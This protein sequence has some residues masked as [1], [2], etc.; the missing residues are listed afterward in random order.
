[1]LSLWKLR[2]GTEAYYLAQVATGLDD[3]YT[4]A[5]EAPG[6]WVGGGSQGLSLYGE[7]VAE[8][9][10]ATMAGLAPRTGLTPNGTQLRPH[11]RR[12]PGFDLTFAAPKSVSVLYALGD[13]RVQIAVVDACEAAVAEALAWLERE[14]CFVRRGTNNAAAKVATV[15]EWGTRRMATRGMVAAQFRHRTSRAG[16]PHLHWH[17]LVANLAQGVDGSWSALDGQALYRAKRTAGVL[18]QTALRAQLTRRLRLAWGPTHQDAAEVAGVPGRV[19]RA[20]STRRA[21]IEEWMDERGRHG[22]AAA[23]EAMA[24]T[25]PAK[26]GVDGAALEA[27][28]RGRAAALGWGPGELEQLLAGAP[29][30]VPA[31]GER[32]VLTRNVRDDDGQVVAQD[33]EVSFG[34]WVE[35]LVIERLSAHDSTFTR[36]D[37]TQA[38]AAATGPG[39][40][41]AEVDQVVRRVLAQPQLVPLAG[42]AEQTTALADRRVR[43]DRGV[44]WASREL[45][46]VEAGYL[47]WLRSGLGGNR[48]VLSAAA[49]AEAVVAAEAASPGS[50]GDLDDGLAAR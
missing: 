45:L 21:Q 35:E 24:A 31:A 30:P 40:S 5:G 8:D 26:P 6:R 19:L 18:F 36:F 43:D 16:D 44:R 41:P 22:P 32:W 48:A 10:R 1:M 23:D 29:A 4:G 28:W 15:G 7:V 12:V 2:V 37:L 34:A 11:P 39:A 17:V 13:A 27:D 49:A 46:E 3:Y 47:A 20:F 50:A 9:L 14:A 42:D 25:R 33:V 38:V